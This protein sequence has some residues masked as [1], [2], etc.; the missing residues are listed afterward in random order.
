V[1]HILASAAIP[2]LFPAIKLGNSWHGDGSIRHTAPLS[3]ALHLGADKL[4]ILATSGVPVKDEPVEGADLP[5]PSPAQI[6][7]VVLNAILFD[8]I[9]Y[10]IQNLNRISDLA[11]QSKVANPSG[12]RVIDTIVVRLLMNATCRAACNT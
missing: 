2:V 5:Y 3:P 9:S 8:H 7:G 10:D 6:L 12:M 11:R 4:L 1:E